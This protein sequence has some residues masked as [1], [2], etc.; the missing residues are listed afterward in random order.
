MEFLLNCYDLSL[1]RLR[2]DNPMGNLLSVESKRQLTDK[3]LTV[4][5]H[6]GGHSHFANNR[7]ENYSFS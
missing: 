4:S 6:T 3:F 5:D 1:N 2:G 7:A